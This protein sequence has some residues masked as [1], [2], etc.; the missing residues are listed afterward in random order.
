MDDST[1]GNGT[2]NSETPLG[3]PKCNQL[4]EH[5]A[6]VVLFRDAFANKEIFLFFH[7]GIRYALVR[8]QSPT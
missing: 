7:L 3:N 2:R 5:L 1:I 4:W 8:W 6:E